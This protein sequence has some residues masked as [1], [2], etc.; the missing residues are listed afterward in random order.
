[1]PE[2]K[3]FEPNGMT[4]DEYKNQEIITVDDGEFFDSLDE[5]FGIEED[6]DEI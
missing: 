3:A 2:I 6:L 1:M 4:Y 5:M